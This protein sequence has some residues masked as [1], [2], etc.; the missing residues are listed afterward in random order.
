[1]QQK[2][3]ATFFSKKR[4]VEKKGKKG[5]ISLKKNPHPKIVNEPFCH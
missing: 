1:M 5:V 2:E 4:K 3:K